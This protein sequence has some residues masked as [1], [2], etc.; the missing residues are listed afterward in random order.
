ME[1]T[2]NAQLSIK[3]LRD[4]LI[5]E[6]KKELSVDGSVTLYLDQVM[7]TLA[8]NAFEQRAEQVINKAQEIINA[9]LDNCNDKLS[10]V[11][12]EYN[13]QKEKEVTLS[14]SC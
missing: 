11:V 5:E 13:S 1:T 8:P 2:A 10:V 3:E 14:K 4:K 6:L 7:V 12:K 9:E